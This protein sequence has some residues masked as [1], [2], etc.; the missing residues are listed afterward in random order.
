MK[1]KGL[2]PARYMQ[3]AQDPMQ[4]QG[5]PTWALK[6]F[7]PNIM[8]ISKNCTI[9]SRL[10]NPNIFKE[11]TKT[12]IMYIMHMSWKYLGLSLPRQNQYS[13]R[14][15]LAPKIPNNNKKS[16]HWYFEG[17]DLRLLARIVFYVYSWTFSL[18]CSEAIRCIM[19][20]QSLAMTPLVLP[21]CL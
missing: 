1:S 10:T 20:A 2:P 21:S 9:V 17:V 16:Y 14:V 18:S 5:L 8:N 12:H 19:V 3:I 4:S 13:S 6:W 11:N 7:S 15:Q